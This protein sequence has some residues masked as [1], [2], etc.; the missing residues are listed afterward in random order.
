M[1]HYCCLNGIKPVMLLEKYHAIA[2]EGKGYRILG[3]SAIIFLAISSL[4]RNGNMSS[5]DGEVIVPS[6]LTR[7]DSLGAKKYT[8]T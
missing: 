4:G 7:E 5:R 1:L 8:I 3:K 6:S 2:M